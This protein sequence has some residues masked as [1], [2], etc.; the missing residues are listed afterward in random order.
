MTRTGCST[1]LQPR[2]VSMAYVMIEGI[3]EKSLT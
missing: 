2:D 1:G 3:G